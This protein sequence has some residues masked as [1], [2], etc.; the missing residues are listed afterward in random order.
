MDRRCPA[1]HCARGARLGVG[2]WFSAVCGALLGCAP[3]PGAESLAS[4]PRTDS[5]PAITTASRSSIGASFSDFDSPGAARTFTSQV[6]L[7]NRAA[8]LGVEHTYQNGAQGQRLMVEA[9]GGGCGWVD[10]DRD[11]LPDLYLTQGGIPGQPADSAQ[12]NDRLFR[13]FD[14]QSF[15]DVATPAGIEERRYSQGIAVGDFDGDGF[16]DVYVTNVGPNSFFQNQGDGTFREIAGFL[17]MADNLWSS[18]AA[19]GDVDRDG[20]LDLYVCNYVDY[21]PFHP[22]ICHNARGLPGMCHPNRMEAVPDTFYLNQGDGTFRSAAR[23][24]GLYGPGNKALGV[25]IGDFTGDGWPDIFVA[26]DTEANFLFVNQEGQR[27]IESATL[28]GCALSSQ[29]LSQANMGV[30]VGDFDENGFPD[31]VVTHFVKEWATLYQNLGPGGFH[32]ISARV[33]LVALTST[34][35]GFGT[36]MTDIDLDGRQ[37]LLIANGHIDDLRHQGDE[38]EMEP[39]LF[40]FVE[41][42]SVDI[43]SQAGEY[44]RQKLVGRGIA[45]ADFDADGDLDFAVVHQNAPTAVLVNESERGQGLQVELIGRSSNRAGVGARVTVRLPGRELV[46]ELM[47]GTSY[48]ATHQPL[49]SFGVGGYSEPVAVEVEWP[50]GIVQAVAGVA[51]GTRLQVVEPDS[52]VTLEPAGDP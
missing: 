44:F 5:P 20:D 42:R 35:L 3:E 19:W 15:V 34:K 51:T 21:D 2:I 4:H 24:L 41:E 6:R 52:T 1:R 31:L 12:P 30:A 50:S 37:D 46:Q 14:G 26:N 9:T 40:T 25:V 7:A 23:E 22:R 28:L 48:C 47:G 38:L 8:D 39:Q 27:F 17:A 33:G 43:G 18:S 49:L 29:G 16:E 45:S 10:Y 36:V 32:D 11:G 13:N